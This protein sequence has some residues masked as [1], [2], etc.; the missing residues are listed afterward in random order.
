MARHFIRCR[1]GS[2]VTAQDILR[3]GLSVIKVCMPDRLASAE[4]A[5]IEIPPARRFQDKELTIVDNA[6]MGFLVIP[7]DGDILYGHIAMRSAAR[8]VP[9]VGDGDEEPDGW[10]V[11]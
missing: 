3:S 10:G 7:S 5:T 11:V 8:L 4:P 6:G 9:L 2:T 1:V